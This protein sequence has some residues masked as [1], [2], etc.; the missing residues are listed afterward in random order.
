MLMKL[1]KLLATRQG[2]LRQA[3]LA[4]LGY[5]YATLKT[6][7][8]RVETAQ[9]SGR[10]RLQPADPTEER[11]WAALTALEGNQSVIEEHFSDQDVLD[12]ADAAVFAVGAEFGEIEF[13]L[14]NLAE[15]FVA[16]IRTTLD[17]AGVI[18]DENS[19]HPKIAPQKAEKHP[20]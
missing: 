11:Y 14:E 12:L 16:P 7:A 18:L 20:D 2:I 6:L 10:V 17:Q 15:Q 19:P 1:S 5:A 8:D 13:P 3:W 9:L 4:N